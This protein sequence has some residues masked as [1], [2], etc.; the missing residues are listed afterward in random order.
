[1]TSAHTQTQSFIYMHRDIF[2][3]DGLITLLPNNVGKKSVNDAGPQQGHGIWNSNI[4]NKGHLMPP[5]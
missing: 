1:M 4:Y 3:V 2:T 5:N